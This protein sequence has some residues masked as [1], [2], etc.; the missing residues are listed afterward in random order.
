MTEHE[1]GHAA[2]GPFDPVEYTCRRVYGG[3]VRLDGERA[4]A[5]SA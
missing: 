1:R 5:D 4:H 2:Y 3:E